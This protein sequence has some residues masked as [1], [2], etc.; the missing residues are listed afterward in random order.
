MITSYQ[1]LTLGEAYRP[2]SDFP[3]DLDVRR[4]VL[5]AALLHRNFRVDRQTLRDQVDT[6][7]FGPKIS[8]REFQIELK[9]T[10]PPS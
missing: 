9:I 7:F 6:E 1:R 5:I 4:V 3:V 8:R 10:W 2:S